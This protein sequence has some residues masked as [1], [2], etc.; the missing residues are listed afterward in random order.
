M[1]AFEKAKKSQQKRFTIEKGKI[2]QQIAVSQDRYE[3][4]KIL[5]EQQDKENNR[6][7]MKIKELKRMV[8]MNE[9]K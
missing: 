3:K 6:K 4:L 2:E 7:S 5:L 8:E 1:Q 9:K